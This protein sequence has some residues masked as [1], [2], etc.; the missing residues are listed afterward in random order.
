MGPPS[1]VPKNRR[2]RGCG[3]TPRRECALLPIGFHRRRGV[4]G[5]PPGRGPAPHARGERDRSAA[6]CGAAAG[7]GRPGE[8]IRTGLPERTRGRDRDAPGRVAAPPDRAHDRGSRPAAERPRRRS[9]VGSRAHSSNRLPEPG[10][11]RLRW[12]R[13]GGSAPGL[14]S[15]LEC[16]PPFPC[17]TT[18]WVIRL[19]R[20]KSTISV[21]HF[22]LRRSVKQRFVRNLRS[23]AIEVRLPGHSGNADSGRSIDARHDLRHSHP[24]P[25]RLPSPTSDA[26]RS[27]SSTPGGP[28]WRGRP[29]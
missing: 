20:R 3:R 4:S 7:G 26:P 13:P 29:V 14:T 9:C 5:R 18:S 15:T 12:G 19:P 27:S 23:F 1:V 24:P 8:P 2:A 11:P 25:G 16:R 10:L 22:H 21:R 17:S 28:P 6:G